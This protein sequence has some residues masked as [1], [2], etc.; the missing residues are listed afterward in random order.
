MTINQIAFTHA[1]RLN[2]PPLLLIPAFLRE[3]KRHA[4]QFGR[5][6]HKAT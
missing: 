4:Y 1:N 2:L 3:D 5:K 6:P